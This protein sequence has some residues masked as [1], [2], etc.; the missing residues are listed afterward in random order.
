MS[1][2]NLFKKNKVDPRLL[3]FP[4]EIDGKKV[5]YPSITN[6]I[7]AACGDC[8]ILMLLCY[9][10]LS[11]ITVVFNSK[12][13]HFAEANQIISGYMHETN[14]P[15]VAL[16]KALTDETMI[17]LGF[18]KFFFMY[19]IVT[20]LALFIVSIIFLS[21]FNNKFKTSPAKYLLRMYIVDSTDYTRPSLKQFIIRNFSYIFTISLFLIPLFIANLE[22]RK[23]ALHDFLSKTV[24]VKLSKR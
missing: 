6:R 10:I 21:W 18:F 14:S 20:Q 9:P 7:A 2:L 5:S 15:I 11:I 13:K 16:S 19:Q 12:T 24:V 22:L 8:A 23:R 17:E 3:V 4:Q 1:L